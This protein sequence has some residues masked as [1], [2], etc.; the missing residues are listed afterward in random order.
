MKHFFFLLLAF[1]CVK[2]K[3]MEKQNRVDSLKTICQKKLISYQKNL[4]TT[5]K[6]GSQKQLDQY[7]KYLQTHEVADD[8]KVYCAHCLIGH[9]LKDQNIKYCRSFSALMPLPLLSEI[10]YE[11]LYDIT[12]TFEEKTTALQGIHN[13]YN[14]HITLDK[15]TD[16]FVQYCRDIHENQVGL[17]DYLTFALDENYE[18]Y[19]VSFLLKKGC[20]QSLEHIWHLLKFGFISRK[21][22]E[23]LKFLLATETLPPE[24]LEVPLRFSRERVAVLQKQEVNF[25]RIAAED[26][27]K[28][29]SLLKRC[30]KSIVLYS[31]ALEL[32]ENYNKK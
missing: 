32:L 9:Y 30:E 22:V 21:K 23:K 26:P 29:F 24:S 28:P 20:Q 11:V 7:V 27:S 4:A 8:E 31:N 14:F 3:A 1:S 15:E 2:T 5:D 18:P 12:F 17:K 10:A 13:F 19:I 16:S 6:T 25:R